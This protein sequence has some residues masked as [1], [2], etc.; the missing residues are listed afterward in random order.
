VNKPDTAAH[1]RQMLHL[2]LAE[3]VA[4]AL[5]AAIPPPV[6]L[7]LPAS[8]GGRTEPWRQRLGTDETFKATVR[9]LVAQ[10]V[11]VLDD[12]ASRE[13]REAATLVLVPHQGLLQ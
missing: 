8:A 12:D 13:E 11:I 3:V 4:R 10:L 7:I 1:H 5:H 6:M 2:Q 9:N